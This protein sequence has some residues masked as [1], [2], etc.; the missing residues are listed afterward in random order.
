MKAVAASA[1]TVKPEANGL[2]QIFP[3]I[4]GGS[5]IISQMSCRLGMPLRLTASRSTLRDPQVPSFPCHSQPSNGKPLTRYLPG[6]PVALTGRTVQAN[7]ILSAPRPS[8]SRS[9]ESRCQYGRERVP[10]FP[11]SPHVQNDRLVATQSHEL[12]A[13]LLYCTGD[14]KVKRPSQSCTWL[15]KPVAEHCRFWPSCVAMVHGW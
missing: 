4:G 5:F 8:S 13:H 9:G 15:T 6:V 10:L 12:Y 1:W 14:G 7:G 11:C 2:L 3:L